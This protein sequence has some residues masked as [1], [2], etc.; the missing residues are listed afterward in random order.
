MPSN[1]RRDGC[2]HLTLTLACTLAELGNIRIE[3]CTQAPPSSNSNQLSFY[4]IF[5]CKDNYE[6]QGHTSGGEVQ[7]AQCPLTLQIA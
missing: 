3:P 1:A 5:Q 4:V 6:T 7:S 2:S